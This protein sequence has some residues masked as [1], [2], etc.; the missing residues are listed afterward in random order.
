M[1]STEAVMLPAAAAAHEAAIRPRRRH[2]PSEQKGEAFPAHQMRLPRASA[3]RLPRRGD[4]PQ[5]LRGVRIMVVDD[6]WDAREVLDAIFTFWG[7][8]VTTAESARGALRT[9]RAAK[10][11]VVVSDVAMPV[12]DGYWLIEQIR[13]LPPQQGGLTPCV[14]VTAHRYVHDERHAIEAGFDAWLSKPVDLT[15]ICEVV[16]RLWRG[17]R[18]G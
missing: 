17:R 8:Q 2:A 7:A 5:P 1:P 4:I 12:W 14:A 10:P 9:F 15:R 6:D 16:E 18:R 3:T 11:D 13:A